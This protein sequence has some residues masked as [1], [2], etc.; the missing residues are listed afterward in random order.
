MSARWTLGRILGWLLFTAWIG[1][2]VLVVW[3]T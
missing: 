3:L 1:A 2:K